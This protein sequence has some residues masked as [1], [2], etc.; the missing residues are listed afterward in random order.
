[1]RKVH[2]DKKHIPLMLTIKSCIRK[3]FKEVTT[4]QDLSMSEVVEKLL[5]EYISKH[6]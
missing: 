1:M 2:P 3:E 5:I 4:I 6:K